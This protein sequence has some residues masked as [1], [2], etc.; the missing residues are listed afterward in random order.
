[1]KV[2][3]G[4]RRASQLHINRSARPDRIAL[5]GA[6]GESALLKEAHSLGT[7]LLY[8]GVSVYKYTTVLLCK[9]AKMLY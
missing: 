6:V 9:F 1:M 8:D 5:R 2:S 4:R 3:G 7:C